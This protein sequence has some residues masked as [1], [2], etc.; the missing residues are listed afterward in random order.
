VKAPFYH[1]DAFASA[2]FTGNPAAVVLLESW[3][4]D[5]VLQAMAAEHALSETAFVVRR[6]MWYDLRWFTPTVEVD[7]CGHAT[8][9]AAHVLFRHAGHSGTVVE[10]RSRSGLLGVARQDDLLVLDFPSRPAAPCPVPEALVRGL[11]REPVK[12]LKA[13]DLLAVFADEAEVRALNP[14]MEVLAGMDCEGV[15]V[16]APGARAAVPGRSAAGASSVVD[17]VSRMF[18]PQCG[19]PEDPVCGSAHCTLVPYWA[20]VLGKRKLA[21][22]QVSARGGELWCEDAG[23]RV[24]I[25][26]RAVTYLQGE[27]EFPETRTAQAA[28]RPWTDKRRG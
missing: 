26:G 12:V 22:R 18:A 13:R 24:K 19:I 2:P 25:G 7:L 3:P 4:A 14:A 1:V 11:G 6:T 9:A 28:P 21:A 23:A 8:L 20:A 10:F 5:A 17:F 15:I 27:V 16:T